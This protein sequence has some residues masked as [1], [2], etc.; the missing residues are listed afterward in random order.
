MGIPLRL[1]I[2]EDSEDDALLLLR[3]LR[4]GDFEPAHQRVDTAE[5]MDAALRDETW[6]LVLCDYRLPSFSGPKALELFQEYDIDIPF[7]VVSGTIGEEMAADL[8]KAGA[9]DLILKDRPVRL[10]PSIKRELADAEARREHKRVAAEKREQDERIRLILGTADDGIIAIDERGIIE[11]FNPAAET[12]FGHSPEDVLGKNVKMLMPP[13][14][15]DQHDD[16]IASYL[17]SGDAKVIGIGREVEGLRADG[18][19]FPLELRVSHLRIGD[20]SE[21]IGFV[22]D[23]TE[24]RQTVDALRESERRFRDFAESASDW[25]WEMGPDLRFSYISERIFAVTGI[26]PKEIVGTLR[27]SLVHPSASPEETVKWEAHEADLEARRS[28]KNFEYS[29]ETADGKD[30]YVRVSGTP[31]FDQDGTFLG[32][33]GTGTD[34]TEQRQTESQYRQMQKMEAVG[35]LTGGIAH[36]FNNLLTIVL[37]NAGILQR[38]IQNDEKLSNLVKAI[39]SASQRGSDLTRRLLAFSHSQDLDNSVFNVN[40][41]IS[42]MDDLLHRSLSENI[43]I[44]IEAEDEL[45]PI[46]ADFSQ[47]ENALLNLAIN[48]RDA[49]PA[50]GELNISTKNVS[51]TKEN[52]ATDSGPAS[53]DHVKIS[54]GDTG[55]GMDDETRKRV[56]EPFFTTKEVGKGT[57]LGLS[58]VYGFMQQSGAHIEIESEV[59]LG[60]S[61]HLYFPKAGIETV[62]G[63]IKKVISGEVPMGSETIL[64]VEDDA[65]VRRTGVRILSEL[66]YRLIEAE[67]GPKA[68]EILEANA[69]IDL[70]FT[71]I[72]MPGGM[73]GVE[74]AQKASEKYPNLKV[75]F[76]SGYADEVLEEHEL[77]R[78]ELSTAEQNQS[79]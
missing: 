9:H 18:A 77:S 10:V 56:F 27:T 43:D 39:I 73:T 55:C 7:I 75:M 51:I 32:Y 46:E 28:F 58:M 42:G 4:D 16:Y 15:S 21:F 20:K 29:Y 38:R 19:I 70:L 41:L 11:S 47:L 68:L 24:R 67:N 66:G 25:F 52:A 1:L 64:F 31:V 44:Q 72:V 59:N 54:I 60:T 5:T 6:D 62:L 79:K 12:I 13:P 14:H 50:G 76:A 63:D 57:G 22:R 40:E 69:D 35:Q 8:I 36:D 3:H 53:G 49:M 71:D 74:L 23:I 33:R 65:E 34:V 48:A 26:R 78:S 61:I 37:G 30:L 2:V 45:W 17:R